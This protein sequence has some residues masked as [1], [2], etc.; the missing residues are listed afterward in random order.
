[1]AAHTSRLHHRPSCPPAHTHT[2]RDRQRERERERERASSTAHFTLR[3]QSI[4]QSING[5]GLTFWANK[6]S[7]IIIVTINAKANKVRYRKQIARQHPWCASGCVVECRICN[8]WEVACSNLCLG[9]F[10]PRSTQPSIP[11]ESV[12]KYHLWLG[13]QRQV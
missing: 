12:N 1:M 5:L 10:T 11:P 6:C 2:D 9:Y 3:V 8:N 4:Y 13:R 7:A